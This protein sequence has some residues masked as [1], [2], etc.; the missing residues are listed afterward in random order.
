VGG[1]SIK[2]DS[3]WTQQAHTELAG[4]IN[5]SPISRLYTT[6]NFMTYVREKLNNTEIF[7][8]H[9]DDLVELAKDIMSELE[10]EDALFIIGSAYLYLGRLSDKLLRYQFDSGFDKRIE[11]MDFSELALLKYNMLMVFHDI[12][13]NISAD[14]TLNK[15]QL[16]IDEYQQ[17]KNKYYNFTNFRGSML[18]DFFKQLEKLLLNDFNIHCINQ[19]IKESGYHNSIINLDFCKLWFNNLDKITSIKSKQLIGS[20]FDFGHAD[21]LIRIEVAT[22]NLHIGFVKYIQQNNK[23]KLYKMEKEDQEI[24]LKDFP[25]IQNLESPL[26]IRKWGFGCLSLDCH[27]FIDMTQAHIYSA[28]SDVKK[29]ELFNKQFLPLL[30]AID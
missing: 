3:E 8:K 7:V 17:W 26:V 6:G 9:S 19:E 29:S 5:K 16:S 21:Y 14:K 25:E 1:I 18:M 15:Y 12:E 22:K 13:K 30:N 27:S 24:L 4:F 28:V 10:P 11:K 20:F 2:K 23:Y